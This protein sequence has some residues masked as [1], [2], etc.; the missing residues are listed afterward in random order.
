MARPTKTQDL[1][2]TEVTDDLKI[3]TGGFGDVSITVGMLKDFFKTPTDI[4]LT[5]S[6]NLKIENG[7]LQQL[8]LAKD[9][10]LN[11]NITNGQYM[12]VLIKGNGKEL[13]YTGF[14]VVNQFNRDATKQSYILIVNMD[15]RLMLYGCQD[16]NA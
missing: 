13:T 12:F 8:E 1:P 6:P 9:G 7:Y 14:D 5:G 2:L 10:Q 15:G 11:C 4:F 3:P 16:V